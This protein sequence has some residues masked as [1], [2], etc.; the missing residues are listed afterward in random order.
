MAPSARTVGVLGGL[1]DAAERDPDSALALTEL[2]LRHL[3]LVPAPEE[4]AL[5][6]IFLHGHAW[7]ARGAALRDAALEAYEKAAEAYR[8]AR[9]RLPQLEAVQRAAAELRSQRRSLS[10][11]RD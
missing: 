5:A 6:L 4:S 10:S 7:S 8:P 11:R 9:V 3:A 2:V 1:L